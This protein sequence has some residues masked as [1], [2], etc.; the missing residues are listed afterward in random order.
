MRLDGCEESLGSPRLEILMQQLRS[1]KGEYVNK[2]LHALTLTAALILACFTAY[3]QQ[4]PHISNAAGFASTC[5]L[6]CFSLATGMTSYKAFNVTQAECCSGAA[7]SCP[8]G[9]APAHP[10]WGEPAVTC[11]INEM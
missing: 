6:T 11:P 4:Q 5:W 1:M 9:S 8:P 2:A 3:P 10:S 7:L